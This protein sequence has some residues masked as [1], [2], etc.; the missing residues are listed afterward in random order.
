MKKKE[1]LYSEEDHISSELFYLDDVLERVARR[2]VKKQ[3]KQKEKEKRKRRT[4]L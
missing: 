1:P 3:E 2:F 4:K